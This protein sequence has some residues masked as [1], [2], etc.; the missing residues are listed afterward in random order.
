MPDEA[1]YEF[2]DSSKLKLIESFDNLLI[3]QTMSKTGFAGIR[4]ECIWE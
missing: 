4:L 3:M 1:Y 2:T